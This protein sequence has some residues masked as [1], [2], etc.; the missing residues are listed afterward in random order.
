MIIKL[1]GNYMEYEDIY[2]INSFLRNKHQALRLQENLKSL[3]IK[4]KNIKIIY[5][6]DLQLNPNLKKNNLCFYNFFHFILPEML[7]T[8]KNCYYLEDHTVVYDNPNKYEKN[9]KLVWLGF[10]KILS[11]Y[12]VGAHLV[13][14]HKELLIELNEE[15]ETYR[16]QHIDRFFKSIGEKKGYL[17]IKNSITQIVEHFS[18]DLNR[19][20][21]NPKN[22]Y[23]KI[24]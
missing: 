23:F 19:I 18:L 16:P 20:R 22:K 2:F 21:K 11:N 24:I 12:I 8:K 10:M 6:Y 9:N 15:K 1:F 14:L 13:F 17:Q 3:G 4:E 7:N 5:G